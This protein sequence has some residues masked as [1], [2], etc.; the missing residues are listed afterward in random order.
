M[1]TKVI[2]TALAAFGAVMMCSPVSAAPKA[3]AAKDSEVKKESLFQKGK[4]AVGD[5]AH[6]VADKSVEVYN[7]SKD[8][9]VETADKVADKSVEVYGKAKEGTV[10]TAD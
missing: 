10:E 8:A 1:K 6:A 9:T 3:K 5:A 2:A 4:K 7:V